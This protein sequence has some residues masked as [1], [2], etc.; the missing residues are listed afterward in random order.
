MEG[1]REGTA[2]VMPAENRTLVAIPVYNEVKTLDRVLRRVRR[3][4]ADVLVIDDG[5]TDG[6]A[7]A[8]DVLADELGLDVIRH[9]VNRGY[10][11]SLIDAFDR[12]GARGFD[13]VITMDCDEQHEPES[14][15]VFE[16]AIA[17][18]GLDLISGSR[19]LDLRAAREG[20]APLDRRRINGLITEEINIRLGL[21]LSD[22]FCGFKAH[23]VAAMRRVRLT[24]TGYA[25][26][27]QLWVRCVAAGFSI[28]EIPVKLIYND[29]NRQFGGGLDDAQRRLAHYR[30][31][32]HREICAARG[33]LPSGAAEALEVDCGG[34]ARVMA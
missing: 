13:W 2:V 17:T 31:V 5:S 29:P 4:A 6:T 15:P 23:R 1:T 12:A 8:L 3:Y 19:Y 7:E 10:G 18:S 21:S 33:R 11:Q 27:M 30:G 32:L 25:F 28:G 24:E 9:G 14:I 34:R 16:A 20:S 22:A 26:P